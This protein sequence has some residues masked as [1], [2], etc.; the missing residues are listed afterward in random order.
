MSSISAAEPDWE[1]WLEERFA[2]YLLQD[3]EGAR[4]DPEQVVRA[5]AR[6]QG[7]T[8][9]WTTL[10]GFGFLL[11]PEGGVE[12]LVMEGIPGWLRRV[13]PTTVRRTEESRG[14]PRGR[15]D[16]SRTLRARLQSRDRTLF[17]GLTPERTFETPA[18]VV[19]RW[20]LERV[21]FAIEDLP[22]YQ[23]TRGWLARLASMHASAGTALSHVALR[24]LEPRRPD[25][26]ERQQ[27]AQSQDATIRQAAAALAFH[28]RLLPRPDPEA[29]ART[30]ERFAL[31]PTSRP[32]RFELFTLLALFESLARLLVG[33]ERS[34]ELVLPGRDAVALWRKGSEEVRIYY[35]Q[36][37]P[38]GLHAEVLKRAFGISAGFRPD[39]R[40]VYEGPAGYRE[41]YVDPKCSTRDAYLVHSHAKMLAYIADRPSAFAPRGPK[42]ILT[43]PRSVLVPWREGDPVAFLDPPGCQG[44]PLDALLEAWLENGGGRDE[45]LA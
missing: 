19:I 29:L 1:A 14:R 42:V 11:D 16:W 38:P 6:L 17:V 13:W 28:D 37:T 20:L 26:G 7:S 43:T 22:A 10:A 45:A 34:D 32:R 9:A 25:S 2:G 33:W 35:D 30:V 3:A 21:V 41:L 31:A 12:D 40:I 27:C 8:T 15:T 5:L 24:H 36:G 4:R 18:A 23:G 44:R 39:I